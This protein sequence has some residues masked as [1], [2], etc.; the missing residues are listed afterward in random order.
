MKQYNIYAE[1]KG[2]FGG[3]KYLYTDLFK[4]HLEANDRA[5]LEAFDIYNL[6]AENSILKSY[7]EMVTS[8]CN[9]IDEKDL[10]LDDYGILDTTFWNYLDEWIC[11]KAVLTSEDNIDKEDIILNYVLDG[12]S[13]K[14]NC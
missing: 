7:D 12:S 5:Y 4:N 3:S 14:I 11:Y 10:T 9:D 13:D 8:Y 6:L 2:N 1:I